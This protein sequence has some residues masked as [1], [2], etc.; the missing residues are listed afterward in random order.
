MGLRGGYIFNAALAA[1]LMFALS[2]VAA[3]D[4]PRLVVI[5]GDLTEIVYALGAGHQVVG[6]DTTS[7]FPPEAAALETVG[8]MRRLSA[9]GIL[10]LE[11]DLV[12]AAA[13][14]G[15]ETALTQLR[16]AGVEIA[17]AP[18]QPTPEGILE[19]IAFIGAALRL[20]AEAAG[21]GER[22]EAGMSDIRAKVAQL[23]Q[24]VRA[25]FI[26]SV[27]GGA[28]MAAGEGTSA[29]AMIEL[30]G[31][32]NS[33]SGFDGYKPLSAEI[34]LAAS[35]EVII[36]PAH[37]AKALGGMAAI[38]ARPELA[39]APAVE[40]DRVFV[41]DGMLL[42]GFGPRTPQAVADLAALLHPGAGFAQ[43]PEAVESN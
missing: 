35:P 12:L 22:V 33:V 2:A 31:G 14:A 1:G 26:L 16:A 29:Q 28:L 17:I 30:A 11:P 3:P 5:G 24:P 34:V 40:R 39:A 6:V 25:M 13:D 4:K 8:Y 15:P 19:K 41:M 23:R 32:E 7:K 20:Q 37:A 38:K 27:S 21:L 9:E 42:L 43:Q 36:A 10:S 18:D